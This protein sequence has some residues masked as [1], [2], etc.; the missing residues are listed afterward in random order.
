ML[1]SVLECF[2]EV[3]RTGDHE[4]KATV[5]EYMDNFVRIPRFETVL[6]FLSREDKK[7]ARDI[8]VALGAEQSDLT[9][10]WGSIRKS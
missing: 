1:V 8:W 7:I 6:L 2:R 5:R 10:E 3:A 9:K 4:R